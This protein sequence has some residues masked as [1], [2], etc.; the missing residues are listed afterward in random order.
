MKMEQ[1]QT[2]QQMAFSSTVSLMTQISKWGR[3]RPFLHEQ[4]YVPESEDLETKSKRSLVDT[5]TMIM[6]MLIYFRHS[7]GKELYTVGSLAEAMDGSSYNARKAREGK[8]KRT[9]ST[10]AGYQVIDFYR[11]Q[12]RGKRECIRIEATDLLITFIEDHFFTL[13]QENLK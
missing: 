5:D 13:A 10:I 4:G 7:L 8:I 1:E 3:I 12:H 6:C 9:L 2:K 11:D